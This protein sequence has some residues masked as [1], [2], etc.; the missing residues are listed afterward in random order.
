MFITESQNAGIQ[1]YDLA[2]G[3]TRSIKPICPS[4]GG[5]RGGGGGGGGGGFGGGGRGNIIP[6][7]AQG[8]VIQFNWNSPMLLSPHD[9]NVLYLGGHQLFISHNQGDTWTMTEEL[10][11]KID[12]DKRQILGVSYA[13]PVCRP[14]APGVAC[15]LSKSRR[16]RRR[17]SSARRRRSRSRP[18]CRASSGSARMTAT[19]R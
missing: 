6:E 9:S 11:K 10:G 3:V 18:S 8:T 16:L 2:T 14:N 4:C 15:I 1:R 5:G 7:P 19:S 17:T 12:L 13:E